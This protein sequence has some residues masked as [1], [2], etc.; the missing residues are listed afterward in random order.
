MPVEFLTREQEEK[1]GKFSEDP[2]PEQLA[3]YFWFD[4][5][6]RNAIFNH[7]HDHNRL[8]FALQLGTV[9]FLGTFLSSPKE[10]P[11]NVI[12]YISQQLKIRSEVASLY[13]RS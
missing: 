5:K 9:R 2:S 6:D 11:A 12:S 4:D 13:N 8:G 10:I 7:R 3:K 1:Y